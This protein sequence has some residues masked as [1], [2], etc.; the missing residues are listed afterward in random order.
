MIHSFLY[1][2]QFKLPGAYWLKFHVIPHF[3]I[4]QLCD[5][6]GNR[7]GQAFATHPDLSFNRHDYTPNYN[8]GYGYISISIDGD[9]LINLALPLYTMS[10]IGDLIDELNRQTE[11]RA[12]WIYPQPSTGWGIICK[13]LLVG[14]DS[15]IILSNILAGTTN[16]QID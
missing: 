3:D 11:G 14:Q 12:I 9:P 5:L 4:V 10:S 15:S 13:S 1:F 7:Y 2:L 16:D 8:N 6:R